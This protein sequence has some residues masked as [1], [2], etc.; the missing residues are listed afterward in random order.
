MRLLHTTNLTFHEYFDERLPP[1]GILS[2][3]WVEAE[4]VSYREMQNLSA[5]VEAKSG[6][7]KIIACADKVKELG[8]NY[9]WID[10]CCIDKAS[11]A[12][13]SEAINSM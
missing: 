1:Y 3:T 6:Y 11:S 12:E 13:L 10:T 2:H 9:V 8:Y 5:S 7:K 4:E